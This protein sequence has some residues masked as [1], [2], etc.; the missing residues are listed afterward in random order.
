[1]IG[2]PSIRVGIQ[3]LTRAEGRVLQYL[4]TELSFQAIA[5]ELTYPRSAVKAKTAS[6]YRKLGVSCR[7]AAVSEAQRRGL[8]GTSDLGD[9]RRHEEPAADPG[10]RSAPSAQP[11]ALAPADARLAPI[12]VD[13]EKPGV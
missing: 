8:L 11:A 12:R 3:P 5:R 4:P 2:E 9:D 1:M 10:R 7:G 13:A 6:I